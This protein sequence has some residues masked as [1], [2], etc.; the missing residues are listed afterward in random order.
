MFKFFIDH[1]VPKSVTVF[2]KK[3]KFNVLS[4]QD[5]NPEMTDLQIIELAKKEKRIIVSNDKDFISLSVKHGGIDMILFDYFNQS[6]EIRIDGLKKILP[7]L[8]SGFGTLI[9]QGG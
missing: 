5:I 9:L 6:A 8:E 1:N 4:V 7:N 2:L 3:E